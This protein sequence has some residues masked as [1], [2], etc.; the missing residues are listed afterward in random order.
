MKE[1]SI[2]NGKTQSLPI[3][4]PGNTGQPHVKQ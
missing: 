2:Y 3:S 1:T 4:G